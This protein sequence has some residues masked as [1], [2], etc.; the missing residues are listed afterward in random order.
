MYTVLI[1]EDELLVRIGIL[2]M[3]DWQSI[4]FEVAGV[5]DDGQKAVDFIRD[6]KPDV[7]LLD[8][9]MPVLDGIGVLKQMRDG[10]ASTIP[11]I[12]TCHDEFDITREA[13]R[14]GA[15]EYLLKDELNADSLTAT[16]EKVKASLPIGQSR[17]PSQTWRDGLKQAILD[18][19]AG[20]QIK[21]SF[22]VSQCRLAL[23]RVENLNTVRARYESG[24]L[25]QALVTLTEMWQQDNANADCLVMTRDDEIL[26]VAPED[27]AGDAQF[28]GMINRLNDIAKLYL[29]ISINV[30]Q[31]EHVQIPN[32]FLTAY[33]E[34]GALLPARET[35]DQ[36]TQRAMDYIMEHYPENITVSDIAQALYVSESLLSRKFN[37]HAGMSIPNYLNRIRVDR[38]EQL[39]KTTD[40]RIY[41]VAEHVGF[42]SVA[43]FSTIFKRMTGTSPKSRK[44]DMR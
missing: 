41:E 33:E 7:I 35:S 15:A 38:A 34:L 37:H 29:D 28:V 21:S 13:F 9:N 20:K 26:L 23:F 36:L 43:Y 40:L 3:V 19:L 32:D 14:L 10:S 5:V 27:T 11:V 31:T 12:M 39:L 16:L 1:A 17:K 44:D 8:L 42:N 24:S 25:E 22:P 6:N 4:G 2:H 18:V 30:E